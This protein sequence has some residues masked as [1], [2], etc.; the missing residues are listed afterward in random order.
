VTAPILVIAGSVRRQRI[1][2]KVAEW[3]AAIGR[4]K[5]SRP[6]EFVDLAAWPLPMSDEPAI[7][8]TGDYWYDHTRTWSRKVADASAYLFVTPQYNGGYPAALKNAIHHLYAKWA[9]K[10]A[11]IVTY[12]GHGGGHCGEQLHLVCRSV[13]MKPLATP[14]L[15]LPQEIIAANS[16]GIDP[17]TTFALHVPALHD[18]FNELDGALATVETPLP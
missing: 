2:L 17:A 10:P 8:Q 6:F 11:M 13:K 14:A 1:A 3:V 15:T 5:I 9:G 4:E 7:P 16:G 18:A 12:G